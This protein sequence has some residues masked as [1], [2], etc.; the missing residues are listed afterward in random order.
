MSFCSHKTAKKLLDYKTKADL[1]TGIK[2]MISWAKSIG[3]QKFSY[4]DKLE[5]DNS[6]I[7]QTWKKKLI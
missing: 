4:L 6:N 2:N 3:P 1:S 7:P 5:L